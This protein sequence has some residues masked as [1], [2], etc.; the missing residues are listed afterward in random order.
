VPGECW[1]VGEASGGGARA[2][3]AAAARVTAAQLFPS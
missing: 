2:A 3:A 1:D